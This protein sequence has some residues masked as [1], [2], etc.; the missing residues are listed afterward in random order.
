MPDLRPMLAAD[1]AAVHE[2]AIAA[3]D[4]LGRRL[5]EAL[6]PPPDP[7]SA[8][9][10]LRHL[11]A[12]DPDGC[13]VSED[14]RGLTGAGVALRREGLWGLSLLV[15]RPDRQSTG[16]GRALLARTL[17]Y[18]AGARGGLILASPDARALRAYARAGFELHPTMHATGAPR[19]VEAAPAV[20]PFQPADHTLAAAA[21]R[22]VRGAARGAD[23]DVMAK[24][25]Y[26]LLTYPD[27]GYAAHLGGAVKLLAALDDEAAAA[28]L[29]TVL[30]RT[31]EGTRADVDWLGARQQW[32]IEV[33][34]AAGLELRPSGAVCVRGQVGR[35]RPYLPG[36][37]FV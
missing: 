7:A 37:A 9:L 18:A 32:A 26:E 19:D 12:T 10:R 11:V 23:L 33:A 35:L 21:D 29:R 31:P 3:F 22:H 20:R 17:A 25:G 13:W 24:A 5:G 6:P 28:L 30:A 36:G 34:V 15:V 16:I 14:A 4:D 27:R 1:V 2:L 8:H